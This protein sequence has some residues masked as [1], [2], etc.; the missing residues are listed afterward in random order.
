MKKE[1]DKPVIDWYNIDRNQGTTGAVSDKPWSKIMKEFKNIDIAISYTK[2]SKN[3][4]VSVRRKAEV[5]FGADTAFSGIEGFLE[6]FKKVI[7]GYKYCVNNGIRCEVYLSSA[8]YDHPGSG[9]LKSRSFNGWQFEGVP[10]CEDEGLYL[11]PDVR[12]TSECHDIYID[13]SKP[14]LS[15]L[16]EAHI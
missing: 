13:F 11:S 4:E 2:H 7:Q 6:D 15:Q 9:E 3:A 1:L 5:S 12:Y 10:S 8:I 14:L 16:A